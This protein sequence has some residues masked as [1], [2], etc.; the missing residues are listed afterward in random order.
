MCG[1]Q[2]AVSKWINHRYVYGRFN[3][4]KENYEILYGVFSL[5]QPN[6]SGEFIVRWRVLYDLHQVDVRR[7]DLRT[8]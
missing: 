7:W 8:K 3:P 5:Y 1:C 2:G 4:I 6:S